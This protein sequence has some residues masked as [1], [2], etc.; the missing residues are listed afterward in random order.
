MEGRKERNAASGKRK[1]TEVEKD[2][3][4]GKRKRAR[5]ALEGARRG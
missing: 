2:G 5:R 3:R 4:K 1:R